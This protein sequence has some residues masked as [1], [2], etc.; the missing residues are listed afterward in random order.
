LDLTGILS[1][2]AT[3]TAAFGGVWLGSRLTRNG[4]REQ[5]EEERADRE[6]QRKE[7]FEGARR[8]VASE[9]INNYSTLGV[10]ARQLRMTPEERTLAARQFNVSVAFQPT[11][12]RAQWD[13]APVY[14]FSAEELYRISHWYDQLDY[15]SRIS[16]HIAAHSPLLRERE[17]QDKWSSESRQLRGDVT[18]DMNALEK[19]V[20]HLHEQGRPFAHLLI[21]EANHKA[22]LRDEALIQR[23]AEPSS[24][25]GNEDPAHS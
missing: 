21:D 19:F 18:L 8:L 5:R 2:L 4:L 25:L 1:P 10:L 3:L 17:R 22:F 14:A 6:R 7:E 12:R 16:Q 11:W 24:D 23:E 15:I 20:Q 13:K 9:V